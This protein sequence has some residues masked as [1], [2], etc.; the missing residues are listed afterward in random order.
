MME[1]LETLYA[2]GLGCSTAS[3]ERQARIQLAD[4][5]VKIRDG[6]LDYMNREQEIFHHS[7]TRGVNNRPPRLE[8][9]LTKRWT[10]VLEKAI[11]SPRASSALTEWNTIRW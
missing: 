8:E 7:L 5:A 11:Q 3:A 2:I 6:Y 9:H 1:E 4:A 10:A